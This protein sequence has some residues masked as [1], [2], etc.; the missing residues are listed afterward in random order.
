MVCLSAQDMNHSKKGPE[1]QPWALQCQLNACICP[2]L[3]FFKDDR[4]RF[5]SK[6]ALSRTGQQD[7]NSDSKASSSGL[8]GAS[9]RF[10]ANKQPNQYCWSVFHSRPAG[11][12]QSHGPRHTQQHHVPQRNTGPKVPCQRNMAPERSATRLARPGRS[13]ESGWSEPFGIYV[14]GV[15]CPPLGGLGG[16]DGEMLWEGDSDIRRGTVVSPIGAVTLPLF[17]EV[18]ER[19][20]GG[21]LFGGVMGMDWGVHCCSVFGELRACDQGGNGFSSSRIKLHF[22]MRTSRASPTPKKTKQPPP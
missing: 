11:K 4:C 16:W 12:I 3:V 10:R 5:P 18:V 2:T 1:F 7:S 19:G 17:L 13:L 8:Q 15:L 20:G 9:Q 21:G 6:G 22:N 14:S